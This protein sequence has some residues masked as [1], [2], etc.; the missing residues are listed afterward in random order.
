MP[1]A[2]VRTRLVRHSAMALAAVMGFALSLVF[3]APASAV[4]TT[5]VSVSVATKTGLALPG[6]IVTA[7]PIANHDY[8]PT[9][10][11]VSGVALVGK[12]GTFSLTGLESDRDYALYFSQA[13][14]GTF[15]Q[16]YGGTT[17]I[18]D[19]TYLQWSAGSHALAVTLATNAVLS[20]KV[21]GPTGVAVKNA[22]AYAY[23][24]IGSDWEYAGEAKTNAYGLYSIANLDPGSYKVEFEPAVGQNFLNEFS[25]NKLTLETATATYIGLGATGVVSASLAVGGVLTGGISW[26]NTYFGYGGAADHVVAYAYKLNGP[27]TGSGFPGINWDAP[28]RQSLSTSTT[29]RW[30]VAGLLPGSYVV[31]FYD[32]GYYWEYPLSSRW[33]NSVTSPE[34]A[35]IFVVTA[36]RTTSAPTS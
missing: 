10:A 7:V 19:A 14:A 32:D 1:I 16:F 28:I 33:A 20:G 17:Q 12:P 26:I 18:V 25:G 13:T 35:A 5:D 21:T 11:L 31:K 3:V 29:G 30:T 8:D 27:D 23:R 24:F 4:A 36:G 2:Q 22:T 9:G 6:V 34:D 15:D